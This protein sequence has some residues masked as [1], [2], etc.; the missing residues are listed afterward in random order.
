MEN[1]KSVSRKEILEEFKDFFELVHNVFFA[2]QQDVKISLE[3][4]ANDSLNDG[5]T[6]LCMQ[7]EAAFPSTL[8]LE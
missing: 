3:K 6:G 7:M 5:F 4:L 2:K 8:A 1:Q